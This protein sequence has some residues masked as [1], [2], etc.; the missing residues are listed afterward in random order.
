MP[1]VV[2]RPCTHAEEGLP[3]PGAMQSETARVRQIYE[4]TAPRYDRLIALSER[5]L[6]SGGRDWVAGQ[7]RGDVLEVA[8]GT[9][10]NLERY[11][12]DVRVTGVEL[13]PAMLAVAQ[14][15]ATR[16]SRPAD[17]RVGDAQRLEFPDA[18][19]DTVV[20]A[21]ALCSIP[22]ERQAVGEAFRV[23]RPGG[24]LLAL[25]HVRSPV[26]VVRAGQRLL[27]PLLLRTMGD[28]LVREPREAVIAAGFEVM[29]LERAKLGIV[30]RL[31]ARKPPRNRSHGGGS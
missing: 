24:L 16:L 26:A 21:L 27:E 4:R 13:S 8:V 12:A 20:F 7:A 22:D 11:P 3:V 6:F 5:L 14:T 23:L 15:R 31:A 1:I 28:H 25:E 10:R 18:A 17:L 30:E 2:Q 19:F 29:R 9:G